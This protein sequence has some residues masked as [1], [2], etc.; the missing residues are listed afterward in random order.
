MEDLK[1]HVERC[2]YTTSLLSADLL[3][4]RCTSVSGGRHGLAWRPQV[5]TLGWK[6]LEVPVGPGFP[7]W[8]LWIFGAGLLS[9]MGCHVLWDTGQHPG[10]HP[11]HASSIPQL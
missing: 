3:E 11:L 8:A 4:V 6:G 10:P 9:A 1:L 7:A 2:P 5:V